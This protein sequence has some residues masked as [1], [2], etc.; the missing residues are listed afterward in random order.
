MTSNQRN[1]GPDL[2]RAALLLV[3][4]MMS[5]KAEEHVLVTS[6]TNTETGVADAIVNGL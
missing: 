6:D 2:N 1:L 4:D 5:V 3:R